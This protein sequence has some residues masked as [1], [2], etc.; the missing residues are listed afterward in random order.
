MQPFTCAD[1]VRQVITVNCCLIKQF[2]LPKSK[3]KSG[4]LLFPEDDS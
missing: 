4:L 3:H 1:T 2:P